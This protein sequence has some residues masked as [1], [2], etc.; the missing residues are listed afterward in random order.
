MSGHCC[1]CMGKENKVTK[2]SD[3]KGDCA[4]VAYLDCRVAYEWL[5]E[6]C[7]RV[8]AVDCVVLCRVRWWGVSAAVRYNLHCTPCGTYVPGAERY[9]NPWSSVSRPLAWLPIS[10]RSWTACCAR[11]K[12]PGSADEGRTLSTDVGTRQRRRPASG[13]MYR[14]SP[15]DRR[16]DIGQNRI[17][18][19]YYTDNTSTY[20]RREQYHQPRTINA[21]RCR[22]A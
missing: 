5:N 4:D 17:P 13:V 15:S 8:E 20:R 18:T 3:V 6:S 10:P 14:N 11:T 7:A 21:H 2:S 12:A 1:R 19:L 22:E 16:T 9:M